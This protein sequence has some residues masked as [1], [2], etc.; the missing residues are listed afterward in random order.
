[1][2]TRANT[3]FNNPAFANAASNIAAAFA[4]VSGADEFGYARAAGQDYQNQ[5]LAQAWDAMTAAGAGPGVQDRYGVAATLFGRGFT[6]TQSNRAVDIA[7]ADRRYGV[8]VGAETARRGQDMDFVLGIPGV[9]EPLGYEDATAGL[10]PEVA[11]Y[12]GLDFSVPGMTGAGLGAPEP[13]LS[14]DQ[15]QARLQQGL[16]AEDPALAAAL[17][18]DG[19]DTTTFVGPEGPELGFSGA[20]ARDGREVFVNPGGQTA[21]DFVTYQTPD[22]QQGTARIVRSGPGAGMYDATSGEPLPQGTITGEL[23]GSRD[24][25]LGASTRNQIDQRGVAVAGALRTI[26]ELDRLISENP[27]SQGLPGVVRG[28]AQNVIQ[29]GTELGRL[30][31]GTIAEVSQA[32]ESGAISPEIYAEFDPSIPAIDMMRNVL[33]WQYAKSFAGNRV[34]NEQYQVALRAIGGGG[35]FSNQADSMARLA[36]LRGMFLRDVEQLQGSMSP[37]VNA[38]LAPY[39][40]EVPPPPGGGANGGPRPGDVEDG[41]RFLGGDPADRANW[42]PVQ[43]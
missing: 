12:L 27:A 38:M 36:E 14:T 20:G 43:R 15:Y 19:M 30:F 24:D 37:E 6:P 42:E 34:T 17:G 28:T 7:S 39:L 26:D 10:P 3:Y 21:D 16:V 9:G 41:Y 33:A 31:G 35:L 2:A 4:P 5:A 18:L 40:G 23:T 13:A 1:M 22:G 11:E 8:D 32:A 25:V 29:T